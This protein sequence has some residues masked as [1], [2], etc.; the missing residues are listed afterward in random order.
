[1]GSRAQSETAQPAD[2][3]VISCKI[4]QLDT[5]L[6]TDR[7]HHQHSLVGTNTSGSTQKAHGFQHMQHTVKE[8]SMALGHLVE[9]LLT[10]SRQETQL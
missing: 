1:M 4:V 2:T 10:R 6:A 8:Q 9:Q 3:L 5:L 7:D